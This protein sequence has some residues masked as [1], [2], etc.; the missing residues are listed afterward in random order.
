MKKSHY[1]FLFLITSF[2]VFNISCSKKGCTAEKAINFDSGA[3]KEDG[4]CSFQAEDYLGTYNVSGF[5]VD[6]FFGDTTTT[7]Y[8]MQIT[9]IEKGSEVKLNNL[10]GLNGSIPASIYTNQLLIPAYIDFFNA[11]EIQSGTGICSGSSITM[12]YSLLTDD[13][14][15][16]ETAVKQ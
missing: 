15:Y 1:L 3:K 8:Q 5:K 6:N 11:Y 13:I 7:S 2:S 4:S 16:F 10:G 14:S 12:Q 9:Q